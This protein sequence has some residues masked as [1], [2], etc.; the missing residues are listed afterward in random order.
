MAT[1]KKPSMENVNGLDREII[2]IKEVLR[3][4]EDK[5]KELERM[6]QHP[7][8]VT[9]NQYNSVNSLNSISFTNSPRTLKRKKKKQHEIF[10]ITSQ[11]SPNTRER[12]IKN[13]W[14]KYKSEK[15]KQ[16][17]SKS[18]LRQSS[19]SESI[20]RSA[21]SV[22]A[23]SIDSSEEGELILIDGK[24][25]TL[26]RESI[27]DKEGK[28]VGTLH[29]DEVLWKPGYYPQNSPSYLFDLPSTVSP[30]NKKEELVKARE[31]EKLREKMWE[32]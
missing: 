32:E 18:K 12:K 29:N 9:P 17:L 6:I 14:N 21:N 31:R 1:R 13:K 3:E 7:H 24:E 26:L 30:L 25:Y 11:N 19:S 16:T 28:F 5:M 8:S 20:S 27:F 2:W 23:L 4:H 22:G 15:A 10:S